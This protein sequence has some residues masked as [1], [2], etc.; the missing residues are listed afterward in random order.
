MVSDLNKKYGDV[1]LFVA[2]K[3]DEE[4]VRDSDIIITATFTTTPIV[5]Q[6]WLKEDAHINGS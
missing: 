3:T 1:N 5:K 6:E 4:C 2:T